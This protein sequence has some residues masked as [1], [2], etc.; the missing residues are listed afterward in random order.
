VR[1]FGD[2]GTEF[3]MYSLF[4]WFGLSCILAEPWLWKSTEWWP[5]EQATLTNALRCWYLLDSS[6]Y[7]ASL[8]SL[9]FFEH[10]R[11]D[12]T[13]MFVHHVVTIV[14]TIISYATDFN[15]VGAVVKALLD[16]GDVPL[17][18]AKLCKYCG[19]NFLADRC[20]ELFA[21]IFFVTR[22]IMYAF[23]VK[24]STFEAYLY[25]E[26]GPPGWVCVVGLWI[27]YVLQVYWFGLVLKVAYKIIVK[28]ENAEDV[29]SD[30]ENENNKKID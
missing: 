20:F 1:K 27:L 12:F 3:V 10:K 19:L 7:T 23:V 16:P 8:I 9:V 5:I 13:Q 17:H 30:D 2:S 28:G 4:T 15:R 26:L 22:L 25:R 11:K 14:I 18:A 21:L 24:V 6:R 29:R